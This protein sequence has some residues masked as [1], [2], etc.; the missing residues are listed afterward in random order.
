VRIGL[1][2]VITQV[3]HP[4]SS[5]DHE[6]GSSRRGSQATDTALAENRAMHPY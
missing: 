5:I 3:Q 4:S 1:G 2:P 6:T